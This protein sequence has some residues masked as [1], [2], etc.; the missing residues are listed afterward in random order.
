MEQMRSIKENLEEENLTVDKT[1]LSVRALVVGLELRL[2]QTRVNEFK[3]TDKFIVEV[4]F[5]TFTFTL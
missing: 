3:M 5:T 2:M 4:T 1:N